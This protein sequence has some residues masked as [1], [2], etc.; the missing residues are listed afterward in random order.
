MRAMSLL[1]CFALLVGLA[2][3]SAAQGPVVIDY[4][5]V[6]IDREAPW[7]V[8]VHGLF[9]SAELLAPQQDVFTRAGYN[10]VAISLRKHGQSTTLQ[11]W[12]EISLDDYT[13]DIAVVIEELGLS[14]WTFWAHSAGSLVIRNY[15]LKY[16]TAGVQAVWHA[17]PAP[18]SQS[19]MDMLNYY[20]FTTWP[21]EMGCLL[22]TYN[23]A[24]IR[25][26][27]SNTFVNNLP[28]EVWKEQWAPLLSDN[29]SISLFA[30][31]QALVGLDTFGS[32]PEVII[33][34]IADRTIPFAGVYD[35][36]AVIGAQ[37]WP[38]GCG[39]GHDYWLDVQA[40]KDAR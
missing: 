18:M 4:R 3:A 13:E 24:C 7:I 21:A 15:A 1:F 37:V 30:A 10:T 11:D 8:M 39:V 38:L 32:V 34:P 33:A 31:S 28:P 16:G 40:C 12:N 29:E 35:D 22:A 19:R 6:E 27:L 17:A 9:H 20:Y 5:A 23:M 2:P 25:D 36:A 14:E 26:A